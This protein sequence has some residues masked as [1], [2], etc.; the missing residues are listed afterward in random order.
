MA[1]YHEERHQLPD[2]RVV[3]ERLFTTPTIP[4]TAVEL[5]AAIDGLSEPV[6]GQPMSEDEED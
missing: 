6:A 3:I 2:G 1:E 4:A 5:L